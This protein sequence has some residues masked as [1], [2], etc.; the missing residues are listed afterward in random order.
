MPVKNKSAYTN[1]LK[2]PFSGWKKILLRVKDEIGENNVS[3]I[4]AGVA[5]YAFLAI[6]PAI[7]ALISIY[8]LALNPQN[9][10]DQL[11]Q[12]YGVMPQQAYEILKAQIE[13]LMKTPGSALGWSMALGIL[14]S[15]WSSNKGTKSLFT[16][17]EVAY[18]TENHRGFFKQNGLTLLFT[19]GAILLVILS[20]ILIVAFP[21]LVGELGLPPAA[22]SLISWGRWI[23]LAVIVVWF[24]GMV[25]K[26]AP[27]RPNSGFKWVFPG[28]VVATLLWLIASWGFSFY[29]SNFGSYGEVYGS[30]SAVVVMLLWLFISSFIILIGAELNS[31]IEKFA[32]NKDFSAKDR[33]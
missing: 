19:L 31:E 27:H 22:E 25:Y 5:F 10:Q 11:S 29:V 8:G 2:I 24:L 17:V 33:S 30:I 18:D 26:H 15:I 7:A 1:P 4:S 16:G 28:A 9:I 14:L 13:N 32:F 3:I 12:L 21:A 23:L 20:M 6:F